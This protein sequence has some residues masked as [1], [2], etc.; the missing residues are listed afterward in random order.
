MNT[1]S[2]G[3]VYIEAYDGC[4]KQI[5]GNMDGQGVLR[6]KNYKRTHHYKA[7]STLKTYHNTVKYYKLVTP[8]GKLL[9]IV[10]NSTYIEQSGKNT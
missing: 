10:K 5:L 4:D 7:L 1:I 3:K 6:A 9:E 8:S 2:T